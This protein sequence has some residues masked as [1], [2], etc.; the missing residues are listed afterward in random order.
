MTAGAAAPVNRGGSREMAMRLQ[1]P[2]P[3]RSER[4]GG[5]VGWKS[6]GGSTVCSDGQQGRPGVNTREKARR[7]WS[8]SGQYPRQGGQILVWPERVGRG[9]RGTTR[10]LNG[11]VYFLI[12]MTPS[13]SIN[14]VFAPAQSERVGLHIVH[15]RMTKT[16]CVSPRLAEKVS[17]F[18]RVCKSP[19]VLIGVVA[20][21]DWLKVWVSGCI[22]ILAWQHCAVYLRGWLYCLWYWQTLGL[23]K[24]A[25]NA[26][27]PPSTLHAQWARR[28]Q[29]CLRH[30]KTPNIAMRSEE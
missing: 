10:L 24:T 26:P 8:V 30:I 27:P 1:R 25:T 5:S 19:F 6:M 14:R 2:L 15:F 18:N 7:R 9:N 11:A 12:L 17:G 28:G 16:R 3:Q 4:K 20:P 23:K 29:H 13:L 21:R 22:F